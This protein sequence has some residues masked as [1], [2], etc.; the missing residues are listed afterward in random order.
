MKTNLVI[1]NL[2]IDNFWLIVQDMNSEL[3]MLKAQLE[4]KNTEI[5]QSK[6][7]RKSFECEKNRAMQQIQMYRKQLQQCSS[8]ISKVSYFSSR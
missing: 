4:V 8:E 6:N 7:S 3:E 1:W 2:R 5:E